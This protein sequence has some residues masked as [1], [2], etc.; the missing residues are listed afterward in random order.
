MTQVSQL[1]LEGSFPGSTGS[2]AKKTI[3][4]KIIMNF[5]NFIKIDVSVL[6]KVICDAA[7]YMRVIVRR[8][9]CLVCV[10]LQQ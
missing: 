9:T 2:A 5:F 10:T 1:N 6:V 4:W 7:L 3:F 8:D